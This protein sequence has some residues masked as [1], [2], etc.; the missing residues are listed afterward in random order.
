M[1]VLLTGAAGRIGSALFAETAGRFRYRLADLE[2]DALAPGDDHE[3][4]RLDIADLA[5]CQAACVDMDAVVHLAADPSPEAKFYPSL[6]EN[7]IKGVYNVFRAAKDAGCRRVIFA[8]SGHAV[9]GYPLDVPIA[10]DIPIRPVTL[11]GATKCFG[12]A[13]GAY[14]AYAEDLPTI[15]IRIGAYEAP[16]LHD[17]PTP[18]NLSAYVSPRDL[19]QLIIRCLE[20]PSDL[21]FAVVNGQSNNRIQRLDLTS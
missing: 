17:D 7:N 13:V 5:A 16:W 6:L 8:S 10:T 19:N 11:Y 14:F 12:E 4:V 18:A 9:A 3:V 21:R 1:R 20:A 15:A 2:I